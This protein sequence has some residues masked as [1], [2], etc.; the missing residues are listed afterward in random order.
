M[1]AFWLAVAL[2]LSVVGCESQSTKTEKDA[3]VVVSSAEPRSAPKPVPPK[4]LEPPK[5]AIPTHWGLS[6]RIGVIKEEEGWHGNVDWR[7]RPGGFRAKFFDPFGSEQA[8]LVGGEGPLHVRL[9]NG[10]VVTGQRLRKWERKSFGQPLPLDAIPYW[11]HGQPM[12]NQQVSKVKRDGKLLREMRQLGWTVRYGRWKQ[13]G[14]Q[15]LP[16]RII[17][18]KGGVEVKLVVDDYR[19]G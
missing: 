15:K 9:P 1:K 13:R 7:Q 4:P 16:G 2:L 3:S 5:P 12:P 10:G 6:G 11:V 14:T 19:A 17:L 18:S 8:Q